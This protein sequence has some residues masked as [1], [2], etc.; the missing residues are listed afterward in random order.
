MDKETTVERKLCR[1]WA[2]I[3]EPPPRLNCREWADE[4]RFLPRESSAM[5]GKYRSAVAPYQREP[6]EAVN[7]TTVQTIAVMFSSQSGKT[8]MLANVVGYFIASDPS[9]ILV[10][11]P[12]LELAESWSKE[13]L[14]PM[15]RDTPVLG[16]LVRESKSRDSGNTILMKV[17]PGGNIAIVGANAPGGLAGRPRRVV[18]LDEVDRFP[19]SA[20]TEGDPCA[21]AIMRTE[22]F[23]NSVIMLTSTPTVKGASKIEAEFLQTDQR[24]WFCPCPKC[25]VSEPLKWAQ[26]KWDE[27]KPEGAWYEC[28]NCAARWDDGDR[29]RAVRAGEWRATADFKGKR[30]YHLNGIAS[31]FK[32]KKGYSSRLHQ[33]VSQFLEAKAGGDQTLKTWVNTFLAETWEASGER[34]EFSDIEKR[35]E[36]YTPESLPSEIVIVIVGAD[37]QADRIESEALGL[38]EEDET[39]GI[40]RRI[41]FGNTEKPEVWK[42]FGEWLRH[43]NYVRVDG[44]TLKMDACAIDTGHKPKMVRAFIRQYGLPRV[45]AVAGSNVALS[46]LVQPRFNKPSRS[47][48]YAINTDA[49]K[50]ILFSRMKIPEPGPRFMHIPKGNGYTEEWFRQLTAEEVR[51]VKQRGFQKRQYHKI[52]ERNEA[53]DMRV[54]QLGAIE[55]LKPNVK[56]VALNLTARR[57]AMEY[58]IKAEPEK[59]VE[60]VKPV[61]FAP[62]RQSQWRGARPPWR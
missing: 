20:G 7:D 50:D 39:W 43:I 29:L 17:F 57:P 18:L 59:P 19:P 37:V 27:G 28:G 55:I 38:G 9:T 11:Q 30:G 24:R 33:M 58:E 42:D 41:F 13:R 4:F 62:P 32:A 22:S 49:M 31:P 36:D 51:I 21:L 3:L 14:T 52:R 54:Y 10:V 46:S 1:S 8:E 45:Y 23:W 61:Q 26:V 60:V 2:A 34:I 15:I 44:V 16:S 56:Q 40:E 6:M 5:P 12:T 35:V 48:T 53:L 47:W 25:D